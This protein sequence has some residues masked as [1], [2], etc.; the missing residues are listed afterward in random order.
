M[1]SIKFSISRPGGDRIHHITEEDVRVVLSRLPAELWER[2]RAVHFN[3]RSRGARRFGYVNRGRREIA[4]CALPPRVSLTGLLVRGQSPEHFGAVRGKQ[5][6]PVAIRRFLLYDVF[7]HELR[8]L[9]IIHD[10]AKTV[11][12]KFAMEPRAQEF[13][14][15]LYRTLWSTPFDH[16][17]PAHNPPNELELATVTGSAP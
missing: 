11:R 17:D 8:H 14:T 10:G 16:P 15:Q 5:W 2:L 1:R 9:Q 12:R 6:S 4:M 13:A 3:D 7:L